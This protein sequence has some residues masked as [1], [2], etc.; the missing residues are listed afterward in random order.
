MNGQPALRPSS[1]TFIT[2]K[3]ASL[4][5][6]QLKE[7]QEWLHGRIKGSRSRSPARKA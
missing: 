7:L 1:S 6:E 2:V 5:P 4:K 3:V